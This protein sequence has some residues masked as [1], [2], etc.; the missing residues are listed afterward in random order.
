[1]G[2][3]ANGTGCGTWF[4]IIATLGLLDLRCIALSHSIGPPLD[5]NLPPHPT[6]QDGAI[7]PL[8]SI[9]IR[10]MDRE[11]LAQ[12]LDSIALQ[13]YPRIE[14]VLQ[15]VR[16]GHRD[17]GSHCGPFPIRLIATDEPVMRSAAAN[18]AMFAAQGDFM[19]FLDDDDWLMPGHIARLV[20]T[21]SKYPLAKAAYTGIALVDAQGQPMGQA[22]DLPYDGIRQLA[23]NLTPI[24]SVLF[25]ASV[26]SQ[27][28]RFDETID[29]LEDW[30]FW[31]QLSKL[32]P[33]VHLPGVSAVYRIHESSGVHH[34]TGPMGAANRRIYQKWETQWTPQQVG[35]IMQRVWT[36][37]EIEVQ[38][39]QARSQ[40][41]HLENQLATSIQAQTQQE[42]TIAQQ[43]AALERQAGAMV[44]LQS[45]ADTLRQEVHKLQAQFIA[46]DAEHRATLHSSSWWITRPLRWGGNMLKRSPLRATLG[47]LRRLPKTLTQGHSTE[48]AVPQAEPLT[49]SQWARTQDT[50][51]ERDLEGYRTQCKQWRLQPV[52]SILMPVYNPPLDLLHA[53]I[54][55][56][57]AQVYPHWELCM[58][59]DASPDSHV[60][61]ALQRFA[62]EDS[63]IKVVR[64]PVNG[65]I[66]HASNSALELVG[67]EFIALMDNDD[68]LPP[69]ALFWV[70]EAINRIPDAGILYSDEDKLDS[71]GE[72]FGPYFKPDWNYTLFLGHNLI[73]H[74]GVYR[75]QL[76]RD[77]GGFRIGLEGSQDYDLAL[78]CMER[79]TADQIVHIPRVLYHWRAIE[80]STALNIESKPY[81]LYA[82]QRALQ[83]HMDR[84]GNSAHVEILP[85]LNYRCVRSGA[86]HGQTVTVILTGTHNGP[87]PDPARDWMQSEAI[88][89]I[90][91]VLCPASGDAI[92]KAIAAA[93]GD[94]IALIRGDLTPSE[95]SALSELIGH[96]VE[97]GTG[98]AGGSVRDSSGL[99]LTGG[100]I[101]NPSRIASILHKNL[102]PGNQGYLSRGY[103]A[104]ELSAIAMECV[105]ARKA[106]FQAHGGFDD[107]LG[108]TMPGAVEWCLRLRKAGLRVVWIPEARWTTNSSSADFDTT[109]A[110]LCNAFRGQYG[111]TYAQW[112]EHDP[113][114]HRL[115]NAEQAD[116]SQQ[117]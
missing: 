83:E 106:V 71:H 37:P 2:A 9:L 108:I 35:Q 39:S 76:V 53:A 99:L 57:Q 10:S 42:A 25:R 33:M 89:F 62:N 11:F 117:T 12:A 7:A 16:P 84:I 24:H 96:A 98:V 14:V 70:V 45:W 103:L 78:R 28:C 100:Y 90:E 75:T 30:D 93:R 65:H 1:M 116:F 5:S 101:L 104:Q 6:H 52:V 91:V 51:S 15:S 86:S 36:H 18:R 79:L 48:V 74:L 49:Y 80:T 81:A 34:D 63:R 23:G 69:D 102:P 111:E 47:R 32:A 97:S 61:E 109:P 40:I 50:P 21:L 59:D 115:L 13:T 68:V 110:D 38:L 43:A 27:G 105:V 67:G 92:N 77:V 58:A 31:L 73:S 22:F 85:S 107:V 66:S 113:A 46:L 87:L 19:L 41:A 94:V 82:A 29:R 44:Q 3:A 60:W 54:A 112:L 95:P 26:L 20:E 88:H 56:I 64:R 4:G 17:P 8:V 55:S 114:Y 72:R